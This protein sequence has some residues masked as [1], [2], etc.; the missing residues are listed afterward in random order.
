MRYIG[1]VKWIETGEVET[2]VF[3]IGE[4]N[5][6]AEDDNEI[7]FYVESF[8]DFENLKAQGNC[9]EWV[10]LSIEPELVIGEEIT[11]N[12][13]FT[14]R[15]GDDGF[16]TGKVLRTIEDCMDEVRAE[17]ESGYLRDEEFFMEV[18]K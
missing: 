10:L 5:E 3:K 9:G 12:I 11:I 8:E 15:I 6:D 18:A 13:P 1:R 14:Y 2:Q 17:I 16:H 4:D 7:F